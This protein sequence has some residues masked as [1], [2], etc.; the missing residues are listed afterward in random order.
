MPIPYSLTQVQIKVVR[1]RSL[2]M[3]TTIDTGALPTA[4]TDKYS[5]I[6]NSFRRV[7]KNDLKDLLV[8][9][10]GDVKQVD[11][12]PQ[13]KVCRWGDTVEDNEVNF[14][15]RL[16]HSESTPA[17]STLDDKIVWGGSKVAVN[18]YD[19]P[20]DA[21]YPEGAY[22]FEIV[23]K[24]RPISDVVEFTLQDK[25]VEYFYQPPLTEEEIKMGANRPENVVGSYAVYASE[26]KANYIGGKEY[27]VGKLGHIYRP[28]ITDA[29]GNEVWGELSIDTKAGILSVTIPQEFLDRAV[30]PITHAAGLT[31]GYT[32]AGGSGTT[33]NDQIRGNAVTVGATGG[34]VTKITVSIRT[35]NY[36]IHPV[37][38][39]IYA[40][41][42]TD[43]ILTNGASAEVNLNAQSKAWTD[44][45]YSTSPTIVAN[46]EYQ[47]V[48]WAGSSAGSLY[49]YIY[50]DSAA[51]GNY[52]QILDASYS[53]TW[54]TPATFTDYNSVKHSIYATT[55]DP[56]AGPANL[57]SYN[58]NLKANI[59][60]INT[61]L[62][63]NVKSLN[64]IV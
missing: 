33:F 56:P 10:I 8:A 14:S 23:L 36:G 44:F 61:N 42:S 16:A 35:V 37:K 40:N 21:T 43:T 12:Y 57:K 24:E 4:I 25:G 26:N 28:K 54:P 20:A 6:S 47:I 5:V 13:L 22:E 53:A 31:F 59:T 1:L 52:I 50:Y 15:I 48:E 27:K 30:Y 45:T 18:F 63:A 55:Y 29:D 38:C 64:T 17:V 11:F 41:R 58:T 9:E 32:T 39:A 62:I 51:A 60:S 46:T 34:T 7:V 2:I 19:L 3:P 49:T